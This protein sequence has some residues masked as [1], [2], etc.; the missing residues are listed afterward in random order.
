MRIL[1]AGAIKG[2]GLAVAE[3]LAL[4][5]AAFIALSSAF[6][7]RLIDTRNGHVVA[8]ASTAGLENQQLPRAV[9]TVSKAGLRAAVQGL[10]EHYRGRPIRFTAISPGSRH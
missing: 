3:D 1:I 7:D 5:A 6:A 8:I 2:L 4:N 10:R 9:Y